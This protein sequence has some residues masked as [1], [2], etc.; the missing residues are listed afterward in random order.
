MDDVRVEV[1]KRYLTR[2]AVSAS[3]VGYLLGFSETS[4]FFR[5]F[6]RWTGMTPQQYRAGAGAGA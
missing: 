2:P 3:E 1:A 5:A 4:A 6:K